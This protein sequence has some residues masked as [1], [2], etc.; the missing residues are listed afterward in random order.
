MDQTIFYIVKT[1]MW[2]CQV[3]ILIVA[4]YETRDISDERG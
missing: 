3:V 2:A 1:V 4:F